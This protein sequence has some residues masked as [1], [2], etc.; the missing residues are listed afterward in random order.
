[1]VVRDIVM[2][3]DA[4]EGEVT[5]VTEE[6]QG[7]RASLIFFYLLLSVKVNKKVNNYVMSGWTSL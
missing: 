7:I 3:T 4:A 6:A 5:L 2:V 1:M